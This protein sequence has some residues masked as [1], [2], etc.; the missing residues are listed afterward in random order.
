MPI[1]KCEIPYFPVRAALILWALLGVSAAQA[2]AG[3][4]GLE[5]L[6]EEAKWREQHRLEL[7][8]ELSAMFERCTNSVAGFEMKNRAQLKA[9]ARNNASTLV[10]LE[11]HKIFGPPYRERL[12]AASKPAPASWADD[13][14]EHCDDIAQRELGQKPSGP[15][16]ATPQQTW[17]S[18]TA[19]LRKADK[20][21]ALLCLSLE[22]RSQYRQM[23]NGMTLKSMRDMADHLKSIKMFKLIG[24]SPETA[25]L[26]TA[27]VETRDGNSGEV[28]FVKSKLN[29][30]WQISSM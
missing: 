20:K 19:A 2:A 1:K 6:A 18:F 28:M 25:T 10:E 27:L 24:N 13:L 7:A 21:S 15:P 8:G 26:A 5:K 9:W 11:Q 29:G 3:N 16:A 17:D 23:F 4:D 22:I 14:A 30:R 12:A